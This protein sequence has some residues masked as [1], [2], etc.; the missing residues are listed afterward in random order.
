MTKETM[1]GLD[2]INLLNEL[3]TTIRSSQVRAALAVNQELVKL[4]WK[5]GSSILHQQKESHWG[6]KLIKNLSND[7]RMAFPE[8]QGFSETNL[9][10]MRRFA[11]NFPEFEIGPQPVAQL[12]WGHIS[13]ILNSFS[14]KDRIDWYI[15]KTIEYAW[16]RT[17]LEKAI[18]SDLY[19]RQA[20]DKNK[21]SNFLQKLPFPQGALAHELLKNPYN[22]DF[23]E[24]HDDALER[25][26]EHGLIKHITKFLLELGKG[27]AF[28][29]SQVP[30]EVGGDE[31]FI[32]MLF[33]NVKLHCYCVIEIKSTKFKPSYAGQLNFYLTAVDRLF[34]TEKD[35]PSVGILLCKSTNKI[36]AEYALQDVN[37]PIGISDYELTKAIPDNFKSTLPSISEIEEELSKD[38]KEEN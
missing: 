19:N 10:R 23:L 35:A 31:F 14:Q 1:I 37:K 4:Y 15:E 27:F 12:P 36:Q 38:M 6:D 22:L 33:Y 25:D 28:L 20:L 21:T 17:G 16:S 34:K 18:K 24:L 29:G 30:I 2:Y 3:K 26:I 32:D 8:T 5:I 7:L 13:L 9:K 11:E